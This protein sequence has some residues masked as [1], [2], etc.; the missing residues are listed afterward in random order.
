MG[1]KGKGQLT[2]ETNTSKGVPGGMLW[3]GRG[4]SVL[5]CCN[6][7]PTHSDKKKKKSPSP[8]RKVE[9]EGSLAVMKKGDFITQSTT[10][11]AELL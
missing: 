6:M 7:E 9:P 1:L 11:Q 5:F 8:L 2:D 3:L 10:R 4:S